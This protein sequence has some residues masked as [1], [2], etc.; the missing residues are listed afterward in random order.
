MVPQD[1]D[2]LSLSLFLHLLLEQNY[3]KV[4]STLAR[5]EEITIE[6]FKE[7][8][9]ILQTFLKL[10]EEISRRSYLTLTSRPLT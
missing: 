5:C 3:P 1:L 6:C 2:K 10:L 4:L 7:A 9:F 8:L